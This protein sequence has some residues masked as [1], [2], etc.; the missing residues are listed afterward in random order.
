MDKCVRR[1]KGNRAGAADILNHEPTDYDTRLLNVEMER[2]R[3]AAAEEARKA[4]AA[5]DEPTGPPPRRR[6]E[7][8]G[9]G[10]RPQAGDLEKKEEIE[11]PKPPPAPAKVEATLATG[12]AEEA[13]HRPRAGQAGR[14]H[15]VAGRRRHAVD[16]GDRALCRGRGCG[17]ARQGE[18]VALRSRSPPR[19]R[20]SAPGRKPPG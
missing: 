17:P 7:A 16:D 3:G 9:G 2:R 10:A 14:R 1:A 6:A 20:R 5:Q 13:R 19:S 4:K 11:K 18:A 12:R 8:A 15:A